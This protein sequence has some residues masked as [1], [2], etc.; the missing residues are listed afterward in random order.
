MKV[1]SFY[2]QSLLISN[3]RKNTLF[4]CELFPNVIDLIQ[5]SIVYNC[6]ARI[7]MDE[8]SYYVPVGNGT[9]VGFLRFL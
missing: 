5:E 4:N 2:A 1:D 9:E 3:T 8:K 7:E 6:E